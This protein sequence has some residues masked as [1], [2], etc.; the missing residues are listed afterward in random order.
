MTGERVVDPG[1]LTRKST[2]DRTSTSFVNSLGCRSYAQMQPM[3]NSAPTADRPPAVYV[4]A[5]TASCKAREGEG[6]GRGMGVEGVC[7][8]GLPTAQGTRKTRELQ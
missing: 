1:T 2:Q 3:M 4:A 6:R 8:G 5:S 7:R